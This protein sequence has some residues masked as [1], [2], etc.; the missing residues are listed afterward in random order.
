MNKGVLYLLPTTLGDS[1]LSAVLPI[2]NQK[3]AISLRYFIVEELR[4]AR[5]FLKKVDAGF[6]IDGSRF[7]VLNEHTSPQQVSDF[8]APLRDGQD[9]GL[10]SEAGCPAVA[11]PGAD[12][13][14]IAQ[15][16][17]IKVVPLVGPSSILL[18]LM[19]SGFNGQRFSFRGYL[20][21]EAGTRA[22]E[23][24]RMETRIYQE[25]E[26]QI[27]IEAP[28]RNCKLVADLLA[29]CLPTTRLCIA[30]DLTLPDQLLVTRTVAQW[31]Q[32]GIPDI[33]KRPTIFLL[34]R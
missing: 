16:E 12:A 19:G 23:W 2:L 10:L 6:D 7:F 27:F 1:D 26:T 15:Q 13:V 3:I 8:L 32:T 17:G 33:D 4:T 29:H 30:C 34:Y 9:M 25:S 22:K 21:L 11:D 28:Y 18:A 14:A 24:K 31:R 5:R 20:P